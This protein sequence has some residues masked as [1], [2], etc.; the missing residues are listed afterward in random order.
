MAVFKS[1]E[2]NEPQGAHEELRD[3]KLQSQLIPV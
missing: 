1:R 2:D 3:M